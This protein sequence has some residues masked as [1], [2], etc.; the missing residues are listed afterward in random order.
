MPLPSSAW[1]GGRVMPARP[2]PPMDAPAAPHA[3]RAPP[4]ARRRPVALA[5]GAAAALGVAGGPVDAVQAAP[6]NVRA[7]GLYGELDLARRGV[8]DLPVE[9]PL[10]TLQGDRLGRVPA[11]GPHEPE[12]VSEPRAAG[13]GP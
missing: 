13:P 3:G 11:A 5:R 2:P 1:R 6:A 9:V 7:V 10:Q 12:G 4:A 8:G